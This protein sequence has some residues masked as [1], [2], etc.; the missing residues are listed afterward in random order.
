MRFLCDGMGNTNGSLDPHG[1]L[2][3]QHFDAFG[4][5]LD[6]VALAA[7]NP[8]STQPACAP[9]TCTYCEAGL[10]P[11]TR[12][13]AAAGPLGYHGQ[14]GYATSLDDAD[15]L[16]PLETANPSYPA[17]N[18]TYPGGWE[19]RSTGLIH[20][21]ARDYNP[22]LGRWLVPDP[23]EFGAEGAIGQLN[24][25]VY[26]ANDPVNFSDPTGGFIQQMLGWMS[27]AIGIAMVIIA[28]ITI[29]APWIAIPLF[30]AGIVAMLWG[31]KQLISD[32]CQHSRIDRIIGGISALMATLSFYEAGGLASAA[33]RRTIRYLIASEGIVAGLGEALN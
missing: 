9:Q 2:A 10:T 21:G 3:L 6:F 4:M 31:A 5:P 19:T 23:V 20:V 15:R 8:P 25:W 1:N 12:G 14:E 24:R 32:P 26:C 29:A 28:A 18:P 33:L 16:R 22:N 13:R 7:T 11:G 27:I 30:L 17:Y